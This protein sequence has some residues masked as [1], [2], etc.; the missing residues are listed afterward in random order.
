[1]FSMLM[2]LSKMMGMCLRRIFLFVYEGKV[3]D[4]FL[5][6]FFLIEGLFDFEVGSNNDHQ[7]DTKK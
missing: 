4:V 2:F 5:E 3:L 7:L 1:M 6:L